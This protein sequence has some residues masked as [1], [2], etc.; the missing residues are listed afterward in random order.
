MPRRSA[1]ISIVV[2]LLFLAYSFYCLR[3]FI[4]TD[5]VGTPWQPGAPAAA[6]AVRMKGRDSEL[7]TSS[8]AVSKYI[9]NFSH[10]EKL[11]KRPL[12]VRFNWYNK[13]NSPIHLGYVLK[14]KVICNTINCIGVFLKVRPRQI[15]H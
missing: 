15:I 7:K 10:Y 13:K 8:T 14:K 5:E 4:E 11:S 9:A 1:K 2:I 12:L 3:Y 6:A